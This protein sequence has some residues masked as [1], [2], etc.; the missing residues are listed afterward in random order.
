MCL[1][2]SVYVLMD[3]GELNLAGEGSLKCRC[4]D[5]HVSNL[6]L[7]ILLLTRSKSRD[8]LSAIPT[9][10]SPISSPS[11]LLTNDTDQYC[12][13]Q[14]PNCHYFSRFINLT[15]VMSVFFLKHVHSESI[16]WNVQRIENGSRWKGNHL[17]VGVFSN[18]GT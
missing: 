4:L 14:L 12:I 16:L 11:L 3:I 10:A 2:R 15:I 6:V 18:L 13:P 17:S 5:E 7:L 1:L 9:I 8:C